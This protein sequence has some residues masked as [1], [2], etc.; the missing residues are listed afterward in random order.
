[1]VAVGALAM[2]LGTA[3]GADD[4][5]K[6]SRKIEDPARVGTP[7]EGKARTGAAGEVAGAARELSGTV[8]KADGKTLYLEH[9]GAVVPLKIDEETQFSGEGVKGSRDLSEGQ[10]VRASFT[11]EDETTNVAQRITVAGAAE[12]RGP[13]TQGMPPGHP[14][15]MPPG[16]PPASPEGVPG[17]PPDEP[18]VPRD[19]GSPLPGDPG[20]PPGPK[21]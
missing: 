10:E 17:I 15:G 6:G 18:P 9:M 5:A 7:G 20:V 12:P 4:A 2:V 13:A 19:P 1:M 8:V 21:Y 14:E 16:H 3:A 11:V